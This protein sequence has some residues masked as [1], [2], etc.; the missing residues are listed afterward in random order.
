MSYIKSLTILLLILTTGMSNIA[1]QTD[2]M[3]ACQCKIK[4]INSMPLI[5]VIEFYNPE[6]KG[7]AWDPV[8]GS[9]FIYYN[10]GDYRFVYV[11]EQQNIRKHTRSEWHEDYYHYYVCYYDEN[12]ELLFMI[13]RTSWIDS[14]ETFIYASIYSFNGKL[15][16]VDMEEIKNE[17]EHSSRI[18]K[19]I[20]LYD[21]DGRM[22]QFD[23]A[24]FMNTKSL[25]EYLNIKLKEYD[26]KDALIYT[27]R[28][29]DANDYT[30]ANSNHV[31]IYAEASVN[32]QVLGSLSAGMTIDVIE[33]STDK[34][35]TDGEEGY[36]CYVRGYTEAGEVK[37]YVFS[38]YIEPV[39]HV[40][41]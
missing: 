7:W 11:D 21:F 12:G 25:S 40:V 37:G 34:T 36:W 3:A 15:L 4:E 33:R 32:S 2:D 28:D 31:K 29:V 23:I 13:M 35:S 38:A 27:F 24:D 39:Q 18:V 14:G 6:Q 22:G 10:V 17:Y 8:K 19:H 26:F 9:E 16:S 41:N 20:T 1:A 30:I 5:K